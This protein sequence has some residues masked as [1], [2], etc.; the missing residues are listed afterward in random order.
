MLRIL[1]LGCGEDTYGTDRLDFRKTKATTLVH[2]IE[3]GLPF[4]DNTFDIV[5]SKNLL[6]H[7]GNVSFHLQECYRVLKSGG[8]IDITTDNAS[9]I[10]FY[11]GTHTGRY[12]ELHPG[13]DCH[14]SIFTK[15]H[16]KNHFNRSG[17]VDLKIG[18]VTSDTDAKWFYIFT[19]QH[20]RIKVRGKKP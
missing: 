11:F 18:Y 7:L 10:W 13:G 9:C 12:E 20:P 15:N 19:L 2:N 6:E 1:N 16:L 8:I 17:F 3:S 5:Y 14:M 4:L